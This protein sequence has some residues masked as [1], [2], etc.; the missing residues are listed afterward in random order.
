MTRTRSSGFTAIEI[1]IVLAIAGLL[2]AIGVPRLQ[3]YLDRGRTAQAIIDINEMSSKIRQY[4]VSKAA[5]PATLAD[6]GFDTRVDP[7]NQPYEYVNLRTSPASVKARKDKNLKPL[8]SDYDLYSIGPDG[9]TAASLN[10]SKS[11]DDV[12]RARDGAF[13]GTAAEFDP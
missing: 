2:I 8:N 5:L 7:W 10:N 12:V 3:S 4:E 13:I 9:V 1:A 6:V 11:R